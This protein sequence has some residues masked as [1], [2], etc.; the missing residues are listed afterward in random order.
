[1]QFRRSL[2]ASFVA[3]T[4]ALAAGARADELTGGPNAKPKAVGVTVPTALSPELAQVVRAQGSTPVENPNDFVKYYGYLND[5]PNLLPALGSNVEATKTEPDK[6][7]YLVLRD[8]KGADPD[9]DY[10]KHF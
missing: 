8:L 7:T 5:Q 6:N 1:M 10:G 3:A 9:Y 2:I 4:L